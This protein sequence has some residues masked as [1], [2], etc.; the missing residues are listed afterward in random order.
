MTTVLAGEIAHSLDEV[1]QPPDFGPDRSRLLI[2]AVRAVGTVYGLFFFMWRVVYYTILLLG[3][4][5]ALS[6]ALGFLLIFLPGQMLFF[7]I[8]AIVCPIYQK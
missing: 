1:G 7:G 8:L 2:Q 6:I 5:S 3:L 4:A